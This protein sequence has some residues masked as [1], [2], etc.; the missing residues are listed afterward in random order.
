MRGGEQGRTIFLF[1][2][3]FFFVPFAVET[4]G[5]LG[6]SLLYAELAKELGGR[7]K[8]RSGLT[9]DKREAVWLA[10]HDSVVIFRGSALASP[11]PNRQQST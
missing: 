11:R 5:V 9:G 2:K 3:V 10:Q 6:P 7:L 8:A 4:I 1:L